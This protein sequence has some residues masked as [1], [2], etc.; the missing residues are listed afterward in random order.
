MPGERPAG[1]L[2]IEGA[3]GQED[4]LLN[5]S[6][7]AEGLFGA[8]AAAGARQAP[9]SSCAEYIWQALHRQASRARCPSNSSETALRGLLKMR[10][11]GAVA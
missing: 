10:L 5:L 7:E 9:R 6:P 2:V 3:E 1:V 8:A 4:L 11:G